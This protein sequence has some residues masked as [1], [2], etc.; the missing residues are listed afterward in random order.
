MI[1]TFFFS[2]PSSVAAAGVLE[3]QNPRLW[4]DIVV[5]GTEFFLG[6]FLGILFAIPLGLIAGWYVRL[7][8]FLDLWLNFFNA[9][10][11]IAL[12]PLIVLW[13]GIGLWSKVLVV[14]LGVFFT[15]V[16]NTIAGMRTLDARQLDL[17]AVFGASR[18]RIFWT[19]ALPT[20]LPFIFAGMRL[21]IGRALIGVIVGELY[22]ANAGLGYMIAVA[23]HT[24]QTDRL[25]FGVLLVTLMGV[26][27]AELLRFSERR[28]V[29]WRPAGNE[30]LA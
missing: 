27:L 4:N 12:M 6:Y 13:V 8:Y 7:N 5:S 10:P 3:I 23:G 25:L 2:S 21:G 16:M 14:F 24:L 15:V 11:R 18:S 1:N 28:I 22:A 30:G 9:A 29:R 17:A 19:I 26:L 20:T